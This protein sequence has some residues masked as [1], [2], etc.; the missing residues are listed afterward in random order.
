M[1]AGGVGAAVVTALIYSPWRTMSSVAHFCAVVNELTWVTNIQWVTLL[2]GHQSVDVGFAL[3]ESL[4]VEFGLPF[5]YA[6]WCLRWKGSTS[7][8]FV[9]VPFGWKGAGLHEGTATSHL[10]CI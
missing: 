3:V 7:S 2:G 4:I 6:G 1:K 5:L 8:A 10:D 9:P